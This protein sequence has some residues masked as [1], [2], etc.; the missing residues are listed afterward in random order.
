VAPTSPS[1]RALGA[2][3]A[4]GLF[5]LSACSR[6]A[7]AAPAVPSAAETD[8]ATACAGVP[9]ETGTPLI[10]TGSDGCTDLAAVLSRCAPRLAPVL[11]FV[12]THDRRY[13]G[14][15][16]AVAVR[17][18]PGEAAYLGRAGDL[19]IYREPGLG[20]R[21]FVADAS[22]TSRW[23]ELPGPGRVTPA[24][25][26]VIGDSIAL[27]S[28][29]E[30]VST[31]PEWST[32][33]DAE[34][35]RATDAGIPLASVVASTSPSAVVVELGTNDQNPEA[36]IASARTILRSLNDEPLV[37]WISPHA[38]FE[39]TTEVRAAI[40]RLV[41][42]TSNAVVADWDAAVPPDALSTDD[43]HLLPDRVDVF[44]DFVAR[45]LRTWR[46]AVTGSGA[47]ACAPTA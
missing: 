42:R 47:T 33:I 24:T 35:G 2:V 26:S 27:G 21:V 37:V 41:A 6:G 44:A 23:L 8:S 11:T 13:V 17:S 19:E 22:G 29:Q 9:P 31:L 18:L 7:D 12:G 40:D 3:L 28:A 4:A 46:M 45:D 20:G 14:G 1:S 38:P 25:A 34:I 32:S 43:V 5:V 30:I 10:R 15:R 39:V 36:F 16:F